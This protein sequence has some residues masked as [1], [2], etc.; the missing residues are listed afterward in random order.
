MQLA[1]WCGERRLASN[2]CEMIESNQGGVPCEFPPA[3]NQG[4]SESGATSQHAAGPTMASTANTAAAGSDNT[5]VGDGVS[6]ACSSQQ[7]AS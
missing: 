5:T 7:G 6:K 2:S 1:V 4:S 3:L